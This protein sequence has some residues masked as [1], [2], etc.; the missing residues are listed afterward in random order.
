MFKLKHTLPLFSEVI[1]IYT[2]ST[3]SNKIL[4]K[5]KN[6]KWDIRNS[7][8]EAQKDK[9]AYGTKDLN[10]L[11]KTPELKKDIK[12]C[13]D[14]YIKETLKWKTNY[15]ITNSW[16]TKVNP[17]GYAS[18]HY[19]SNSWLSGVYYPVAD[20]HFKIRFY[21]SKPKQFQDVTTEYN[22]YNST[23]WDIPVLNNNTLIIFNSLL[24]HEVLLNK[25]NKTRYSIAL[26][27]FPKGFIGEK[28]SDSSL[29]L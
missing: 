12:E 20:E 16:L 2:T 9:E 17:G 28:N 10:F 23:F 8:L 18:A 21:N 24:N 3:D 4:K 15:R 7:G 26:N 6:L 1:G 29:Q 22:I 27:I 5:L 13:F 11:S 14:H 25:S 19:H